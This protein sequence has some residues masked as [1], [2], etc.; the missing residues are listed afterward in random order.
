MATEFD[1]LSKQ[2]KTLRTIAHEVCRRYNREPTK[3]HLKQLKALMHHCGQHVYIEYQF[4]CDY[5]V[6]IELGDRVYINKGCTFLDAGKI[7]IG[8]DCLIG[9][10][11]Q[12]ITVSH[13]TNSQER[14]EKK[15]FKDDITIGKNVWLGAGAIVLAGVTIGDNAIVGA[16]SVV[17]RNVANNTTV[18]GNPARVIAK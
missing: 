11:V 5:G 12:L 1:S 13:S 6:Y 18:A 7:V 14:L 2:N 17:T 10:N 16:G 3:G 15:N 4:H 9:P 8:D